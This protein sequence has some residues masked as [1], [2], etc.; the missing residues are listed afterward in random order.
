MKEKGDLTGKE[1]NEYVC[2]SSNTESER[3]GGDLRDYKER[4]WK[5]M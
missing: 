3:K 5:G 2:T 4:E 1:I